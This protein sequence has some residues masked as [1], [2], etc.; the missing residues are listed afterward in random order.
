MKVFVACNRSGETELNGPH[1][2]ASPF[3][4]QRAAKHTYA[5]PNSVSEEVLKTSAVAGLFPNQPI[6][7]LCY[8]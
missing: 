3:P 2:A 7:G 4:V 5:V 6:P 8:P 1:E